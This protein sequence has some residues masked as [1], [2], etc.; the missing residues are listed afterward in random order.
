MPGFGERSID[1]RLQR[2]GD[3]DVLFIAPL[4]LIDRQFDIDEARVQDSMRQVRPGDW[5]D[6]AGRTKDVLLTHGER[7]KKGSVQI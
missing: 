5:I 1:E 7:S 2:L 6:M 3:A 4:I